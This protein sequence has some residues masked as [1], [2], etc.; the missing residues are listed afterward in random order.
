[1][2][3]ASVDRLVTAIFATVCVSVTAAWAALLVRGA[4]WLI[5][6]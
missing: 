6:Y 2:R 4:V 1:V 5:S 3:D